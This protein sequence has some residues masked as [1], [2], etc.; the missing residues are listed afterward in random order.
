MKKN[1]F[2]FTLIEVLV[3]ISI[4]SI[5]S[6]V[7]F[8]IYNGVLPKARDAK[9]ISDL[10]KLATALEIYYQKKG[11]YIDG[12]PGLEGSCASADTAAFYTEI[13]DYITD[14]KVPRD[15]K[16]DPY[17]Y[18]SVADGQSFRLFAKLEDC[19]A[20]GGNLCAPPNQN[21]NFS[22]YSNDLTLSPPVPAPSPTPTPTPLPSP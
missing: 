20:S 6:T 14:P 22:V 1:H 21:Y 12:T 10:N 9:R 2:G 7:G 13:K 15:P 19:Q 4:L 8:I 16:E 18:N 11:K 17:C 3:T 5:L